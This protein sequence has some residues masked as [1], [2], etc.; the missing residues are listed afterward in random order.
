[1]LS[2]YSSNGRRKTFSKFSIDTLPALDRRECVFEQPL[3]EWMGSSNLRCSE[4]NIST[5][6]GDNS[7]NI[8]KL[9]NS[10]RNRSILLLLFRESLIFGDFLFKKTRNGDCFKYTKKCLELSVAILKT[11][12]CVLQLLDSR[13]LGTEV[14]LY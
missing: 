14:H 3:F 5:K 10:K 4:L 13:S 6:F 1:M 8:E 12:Y 11:A 7:I 9:P 2:A